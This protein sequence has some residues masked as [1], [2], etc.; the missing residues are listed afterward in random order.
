MIRRPPRSTRTDTL[1]PYTTLVRSKVVV[2][3]GA[4]RIAGHLGHMRLFLANFENGRVLRSSLDVVCEASWRIGD[5]DRRRGCCR[6]TPLSSATMGI[7]ARNRM[8]RPLTFALFRNSKD[9]MLLKTK[10]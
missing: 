2:E 6:R 4:A 9:V 3:C 5:A 1:F 7:T 10:F 8:G